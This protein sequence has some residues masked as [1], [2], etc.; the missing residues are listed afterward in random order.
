MQKLDRPQA[1]I[2]AFVQA[3]TLGPEVPSAW[4]GLAL[5]Y[6][7][8]GD[9]VAAQRA[10]SRL[11]ALDPALAEQLRDAVEQLRVAP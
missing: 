9:D 8:V 5:A 3:V 6:A 10:G 4:Y 11:A 1:A 7:S 2:R